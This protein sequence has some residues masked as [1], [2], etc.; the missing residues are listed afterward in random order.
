MLPSAGDDSTALD[1]Y[2]QAVILAPCDVD[3]GK[4]EDL[5]IT[6]ANRAAVML[7][8]EKFS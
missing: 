1:C 2:N 6:L 8:R 5:A 4:G 7:R 3:T